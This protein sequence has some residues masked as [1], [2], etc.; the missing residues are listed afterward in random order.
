MNQD[1]RD[2]SPKEPQ[3]T[4]CDVCY[5]LD[6][7]MTVKLCGY[8]EMCSSWICEADMGNWPRRIKAAIKAQGSKE[9]VAG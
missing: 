9:A 1:E 7:D 2:V 6:N 3:L 4:I 8:C 5:L